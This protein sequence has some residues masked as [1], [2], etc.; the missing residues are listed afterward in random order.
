MQSYRPYNV[1]MMRDSPERCVIL[2]VSGPV[3]NV[4]VKSKFENRKERA[5]MLPGS[6]LAT[7]LC[8]LRDEDSQT[9]NSTLQTS[10][11]FVQ[12]PISLRILRLNLNFA[13]LLGGVFYKPPS[14]AVVSL[15]GTFSTQTCVSCR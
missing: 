5:E 8:W 13:F 4:Q 2:S 1:L 12:I 15:A 14:L 9:L 7:P 3:N 11:Y 6:L 10:I